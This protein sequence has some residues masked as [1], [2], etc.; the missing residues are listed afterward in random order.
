MKTT[1]CTWED[2]TSNRQVQFSV[3]YTIENGAVTIKTVTPNKVS[4]VCPE[5]NTVKN[6]VGVHTETG[7]NLL[8]SQFRNSM[9]FERLATA[10]ANP[11]A[12]TVIPHTSIRLDVSTV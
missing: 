7:R 3:E 10:I 12:D 9:G 2:E 5:T 6:S 8:S 4:F 11:N 1:L